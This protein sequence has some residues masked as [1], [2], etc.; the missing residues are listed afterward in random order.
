METLA[1]ADGDL[2]RGAMF[3]A[4]A[5][6][7]TRDFDG[8]RIPL[9]RWER[10]SRS[11]GVVSGED[12]DAR[13]TRVMRDRLST[14]EE[15][16]ASDDPWQGAID[17]AQ[18]EHDAAADLHR[19]AAHLRD[20]L[21]DG[22]RLSSWA[23]LSTWC[24][25]LFRALIGPGDES[26]ALPAEEQY[27]VAA[28]EATLQSSAALDAFDG[29]ADLPAL[30]DL[31]DVELTFALPRVGRLGDG[32]LV[33][34]VSAAVGLDVD[35]VYIVGLAEDLYPGR[36][37]EDALLPDRLR[38]ASG[39]ELP[40]HRERL[41][42][43]QRHLLAAFA[44]ARQRSIASFPR[45]DLRRSS[46]RLPSRWVLPTLREL[47]SDTS[48]AATDWDLPAYHTTVTGSGS[49]AAS[50]LETEWPMNDQ[51]WR[52][53]ALSGADGRRADG[54]GDPIVT[55]AVA[56]IRA[57][58]SDEFTRYDGNLAGAEG[59][60]DFAAGAR[61][62]SPTALEKYAECPHAYFVERLLGVTQLEQPEE[63]V[64]ISPME[65][66]NLVHESLD[67]LVHEFVDDL[68]SFGQPWRPEQRARLA[69]IAHEKALEFEAQGLT[70]H[71][72]LWQREQVR[73]TSDLAWLLDDDDAW[74]ATNDARVET[75]EMA[76][77]LDG[78]APATVQ[79]DGGVV[80]MR[81]SADKVDIGRDGTIFV[82]DVKTGGRSRFAK[83]AADTPLG[84]GTKLQ[85]PVYA[86]AARE[87]FG[88]RATPV[89]AAYWFVRKDRGR[90]EIP[91]TPDVEAAYAQTLG[92]IVASIATGNFPA[93]APDSPD[94]SWVQCDYCNPDGIGH[95]DV[96][97]RWERKRLAPELA[98]YVRLV[99]PEALPG[100]DD[101]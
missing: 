41:R 61:R 37:H 7:P 20:R 82:T 43:R 3:R 47:S 46:R 32:L 73:I 65:I 36:L 22:A 93:R 56:T 57:R 69:A 76:F 48:L 71:P 44:A 14:I 59:L 74:R 78:H 83:I 58:A 60:P 38:S 19:F 1:L 33:A 50:L 70:G 87:R 62:V 96:R 72:R 51:E 64:A 90:I 29:E 55:A 68:P 17:R 100:G 25:E 52:T 97:R 34:P 98:D 8:R 27:A 84:D 12:W 54:L 67:Q 35:L 28:I 79:V 16:Q 11:A 10:V 26:T 2:P 95:V 101:A 13:L 80:L 9:A 88:D 77:G 4:L 89:R 85:L 31:L 6:A 66:G 49:Y 15:L 91:L 86:Y 94:W 92:T 39:G 21:N 5:N 81:G 53:R 99:E 45:G 63:I 42:T 23:D 24:L 75:S 30:R 40:L 18:R